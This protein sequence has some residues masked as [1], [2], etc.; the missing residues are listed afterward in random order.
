MDHT[1]R[2]R[3]VTKQAAWE[4]LD[5]LIAV[6]RNSGKLRRRSSD[7]SSDSNTTASDQFA[8]EWREERRNAR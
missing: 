7:P 8:K 2:C 1:R 5:R 3:P 6:A 4:R